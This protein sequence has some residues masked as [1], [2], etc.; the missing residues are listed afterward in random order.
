M[1]PTE[2]LL[3][4]LDIILNTRPGDLPWRPEFGCDLTDLVGEAATSD[5]VDLTENQ[6]KRAIDVWLSDAILNNCNVHLV[7]GQGDVIHH[8]EASIPTAES[9]L[10]AMGTEARLEVKLDIEVDEESLE[11]GAEL[12]L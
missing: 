2:A 5:R 3:A 9:A 6:V 11:V 4:R 8:R 10:V 1:N 12:E 7:T